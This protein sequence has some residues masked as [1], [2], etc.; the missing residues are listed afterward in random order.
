M[1]MRFQELTTRLELLQEQGLINEKVCRVTESVFEELARLVKKDSIEQAEMVFT[2][3]PLALM[4][5]VN[6]ENIDRPDPFILEEMKR[7]EHFPVAETLVHF[8]EKLWE[9]SLPQGE[10]DFLYIH[11][12]NL[13]NI[14]Q[15]GDELEDCHRGTSGEE[16]DRR[17]N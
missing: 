6:G 16:G 10:K 15:G 4:R 2:H 5:I 1:I 7:S 17:K 14:N 11:F 9:K 12:I 8:I 3:L 13:L